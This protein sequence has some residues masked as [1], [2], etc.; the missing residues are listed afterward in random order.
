MEVKSMIK[1]ETIT[2]NGKQFTKN[3]SDAGYY[4]QKVGTEEVYS[5]AIDP[6]DSGRT[7]VETDELMEAE[8]FTAEKALDI[9]VGGEG[10]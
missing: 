2:I 9:I 10:V 1:T 4:I 3:Y 7:Y 8:E 5:E 6:V